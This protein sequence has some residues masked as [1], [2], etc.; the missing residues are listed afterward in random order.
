MC[1]VKLCKNTILA[2]KQ[3]RSKEKTKERNLKLQILFIKIL[4]YWNI[5][6]LTAFFWNIS[7]IKVL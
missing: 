5:I 2:I 7:F 6:F 4:V 1:K 3:I